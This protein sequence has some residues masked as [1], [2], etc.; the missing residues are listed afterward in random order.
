MY[1]F[2]YVLKE[3]W[4]WKYGNEKNIIIPISAYILNNR[5]EYYYNLNLISKNFWKN[6]EYDLERDWQI[7]IYPET[8]DFYLYS[9]YT[10]LCL[11]FSKVLYNSFIT[12]FKEEINF[13]EKY[14]KLTEK[15]D[16]FLDLSDKNKWLVW[17][18]LVNWKG[19][20][21]K[22]KLDYLE[23]VWVNVNEKEQ[24]VLKWIYEEIYL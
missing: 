18:I 1:L 7:N 6:I 2:H 12:D 22:A 21:S 8:K 3:L 5:D 11:Y 20:I 9:D 24:E 10:S 14:Y 16:D 15:I 13:L 17:K 4:F 19:I 23:K